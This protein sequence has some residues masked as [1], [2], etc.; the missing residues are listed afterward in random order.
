[1]TTTAA[2]LLKE[3]TSRGD[4]RQAERAARFFKTGKGQYG[5]H[6][7]FVGVMMPELLLM[8]RSHV[9]LSL[10]ETVKLLKTAVHEAR[11]LAL[12]VLVNKFRAGDSAEKDAVARCYLDNTDYVNNWDLVDSSAHLILG[13]WLENRDRNI[14]DTL[15]GSSSLWERR[16]AIIA[17]FHFIRKGKFADALRIAG[18]LVNDSEDLLHKAVGWMLREIGNRDRGT[19]EGFLMEHY[20]NMP[21][22]MLR[23]A[24]EKFPEPLRKAYLAGK[25]A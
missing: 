8:A 16:I 18:L 5:E 12:L 15:A 22:T 20:R 13:P 21:R 4:A 2:A 25:I 9:E 1:M 19:E 11:L 17:T 7:V 10:D 3:L 23:Y 14:L 24:I 6:E